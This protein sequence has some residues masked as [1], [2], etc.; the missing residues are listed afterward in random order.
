MK[1]DG[2][3]CLVAPGSAKCLAIASSDTAPVLVSLGAEAILQNTQGERRVKLED[4]YRDDGIDYSAKGRD[5]ILKA[6][7]IPRDNLIRRNAYLKLRRRGSFD[8][9]IL[10]VAATMEAN[11]EGE[12]R[13]ASVV[14][15]AV[16]SAP[17]VVVEASTLLQGKKVTKELI[18]TVA[19][20]AAKISRPLDNA[21]LDYWYRK[22]MAKVF[23]QRALAQVAGLEDRGTGVME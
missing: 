22:R 2:D 9:P 10:G 15:T 11:Q 5:E 19:D 17:K 6:L 21:D 20:A 8:F 7:L 14:L 13:H 3:I 12:C 18:D 4:L 16:A 23:T 1:K